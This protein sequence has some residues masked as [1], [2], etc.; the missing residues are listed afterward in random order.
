MVALATEFETVTQSLKSPLAGKP[1]PVAAVSDAC[2]TAGNG[3]NSF[4]ED[5]LKVLID[6]V[7]KYNVGQRP[8]NGSQGKNP[9]IVCYNCQ[10]KGHIARDC[11]AKQPTTTEPTTAEQPLN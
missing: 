4:T 3:Q 2:A 7:K 8:R 11:P 1:E 9:N 5:L 10:N 6:L